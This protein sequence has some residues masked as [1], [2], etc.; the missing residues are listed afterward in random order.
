MFS[1]A[2]VAV[3]IAV[4]VVALPHLKPVTLLRITLVMLSLIYI[5]SPVRLF[6]SIMM[7]YN[8]YPLLLSLITGK[9]INMQL[10][11]SRGNTFN[12]WQVNLEFISN[13]DCIFMTLILR[14]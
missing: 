4:M 2:A 7:R 11:S 3:A 12:N 13:Y 9:F 14:K 1:A 5:S 6:Q 10:L 8:S